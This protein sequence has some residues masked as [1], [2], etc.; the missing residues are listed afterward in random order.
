MRVDG[1]TVRVV[2]GGGAAVA[3][4]RDEVLRE[5]A[6]GVAGLTVALPQHI[7]MG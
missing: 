5:F 1:G 6:P 4:W 2:G 7:G 3:G